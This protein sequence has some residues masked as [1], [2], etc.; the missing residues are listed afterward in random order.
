MVRKARA[1]LLLVRLRVLRQQIT[2]GAP[3]HARVLVVDDVRVLVEHVDRAAEDRDRLDVL[4]L[5]VVRV[6][7]G[8]PHLPRTCDV[9]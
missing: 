2:V 3:M 8:V 1:H 7:E 9:P 5:D 4:I 6:E